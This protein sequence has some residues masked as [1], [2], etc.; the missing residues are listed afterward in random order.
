MLAVHWYDRD[1]CDHGH[2]ERWKWWVL[3]SA[4]RMFVFSIIVFCIHLFRPWLTERPR[5]LAQATNT[6]NIVDA[7]GLIWFVVGNIWLF[8]DDDNSCRHPEKSPIYG[9]G[10]AMLIISY[11]QICLPCI[12]AV[13]LI[14]LF[15]FCMPCLIRALARLQNL[16]PN[17]VSLIFCI[18]LPFCLSACLSVCVFVFFVDYP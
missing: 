12:I 17:V 18:G 7:L 14:P 5:Y 13:A 11:I 2:T 9:V 8:G 4:I 6:R 1:V 15:C 3:I 16:R 10:V